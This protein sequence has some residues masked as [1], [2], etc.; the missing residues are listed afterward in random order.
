MQTRMQRMACFAVVA[1][2]SVVLVGGT[3][4][5]QSNPAFGTWKMNLTKSKYDPGPPPMSDTRVF[6]AWE[7]DGVKMTFTVVQADGT[8]VVTE[9]SGHYDGKD[10]NLKTAG[11]PNTA[12]MSLRRVSA[13][14]TEYMIKNQGKVIGTG[15]V[16]VARNGKTQTL[17]TTSGTNAKGQKVHN[18]TV[19]DK[20]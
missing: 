8:R 1:V 2:A 3:A 7:G 4:F 15:K 20:Q 16:V 17:R 6:E 10:Y 9:F 11:A 5:A 18:V 14:T 13:N 12:T 19:W